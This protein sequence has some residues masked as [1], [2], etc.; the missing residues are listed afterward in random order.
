MLVKEEFLVLLFG[1]SRQELFSDCRVHHRDDPHAVLQ[2]LQGKEQLFQ[3][4]LLELL[5]DYA[6]LV[7]IEALPELNHLAFLKR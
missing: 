2:I 4:L 7:V 3:L 6:P 1:E 5:Q